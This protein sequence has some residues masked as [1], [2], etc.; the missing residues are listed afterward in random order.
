MTPYA[1]RGGHMNMNMRREDHMDM[2]MGVMC[3]VTWGSRGGSC[4]GH[5]AHTRPTCSMTSQT[6]GVAWGSHGG[7]R[8]AH[9][10]HDV[11]CE[12]AL[13]QGALEAGGGQQ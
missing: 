7:H 6:K 4:G 10:Q 2:D 13:E 3:G 9:L 12:R 8:T 11:V 1:K 5:G